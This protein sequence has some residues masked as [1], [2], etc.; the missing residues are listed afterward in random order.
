MKIVITGGHFSPAYSVIK[1]LP[2]SDEVLVLGRKT[3]FEGN[4]NES[5]EY[6]ICREHHIPFKEIRSGRLQ[7]KLTKYTLPSLVKI[8]VGF[9]GALSALINYKPDVVLTFGGYI[10][11]PVA[12]AAKMMGI[13][14][15]L[16]EQTQHAG[17]AAKFIGKFSAAVCI[18]FES[19]RKYFKNKNVILTGNPIREEPTS[20]TKTPPISPTATTFP[21]RS[22]I[23]ASDAPNESEPTSPIQSL[24]LY[25]LK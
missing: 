17:L 25:I 13:P 2:K 9:W 16:H 12:F 20:I 24:A 5:F 18:S 4:S 3:T 22:P 8:P 10:G 21:V 14:V 19:S 15:I 11:L 23:T 1:Q 7:R 6:K